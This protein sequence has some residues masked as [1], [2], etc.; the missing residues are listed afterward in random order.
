MC[1]KLN[2]F[3]WRGEIQRNDHRWTFKQFSCWHHDVQ[4]RLENLFERHLMSNGGV[5]NSQK[6]LGQMGKEF[7]NKNLNEIFLKIW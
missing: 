7:K 6:N 1:P 4:N 5:D 3:I 2:I